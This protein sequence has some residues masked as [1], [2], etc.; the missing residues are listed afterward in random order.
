[1]I[2]S[3]L[4]LV[5]LCLQLSQK[6]MSQYASSQLIDSVN[7]E[8]RDKDGGSF[9]VTF[10]LLNGDSPV[11][12]TEKFCNLYFLGEEHCS[13]LTDR[14]VQLYNLYQQELLSVEEV[15]SIV[16]VEGEEGFEGGEVVIGIVPVVLMSPEGDTSEVEFTLNSIEDPTVQG[17]WL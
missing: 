13:M 12:Q 11:Q 14:A 8:L 17:M 5:V 3:V 16:L 6:I 9:L 1:M 15:P 10:E 7:I 2:F 4:Y